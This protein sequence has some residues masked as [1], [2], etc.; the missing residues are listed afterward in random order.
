MASATE[1]ANAALI[2]IGADRI[3]ALTDNNDRARVINARYAQVRDAELRRRRWRFA[4]ERTTLPAL[5]AAPSFGYANQYQLPADYLRLITIGEYD[6]GVNL[7]DYR[8]ASSALFSV[9]GGKLLTNL[10]APLAIR[11]IKRVTDE[12]LFDSAF[13]E[14]F[15]SRLAYEIC[16]RLT[17]SDSKKQMAWGDYQE[18]I[19]EAIRANAIETAPEPVSD[20]TWVMARLG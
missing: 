9:E 5:S 2:K 20:D 1:I 14:A 19:R 12:A 18:S 6:L 11:Y 7:S 4:T 10:G 13:A 8:S 17:Q 16:E 3:T 15:A